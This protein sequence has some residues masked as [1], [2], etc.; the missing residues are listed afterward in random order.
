MS[1]A[2]PAIADR[3][4]DDFVL[5]LKQHGIVAVGDPAGMI[6]WAHWACDQLAQG[7]SAQ[8]VVVWL[9][10][11][12]PVGKGDFAATDALFLR[13]ATVYYCPAYRDAAA[14]I[15]AR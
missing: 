3:H 13:T 9:D 15:A 7:A 14:T 1:R 6:G 10:G 12:N 2:V 5:A 4:D 11:Y 8:N